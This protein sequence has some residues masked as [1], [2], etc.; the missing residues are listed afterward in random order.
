MG[1]HDEDTGR[2]LWS[3]PAP[4]LCAT[5]AMS[6]GWTQQCA[7]VMA[8]LELADDVLYIGRLIESLDAGKFVGSEY[9]LAQFL[10]P[11]L[12]DGRLRLIAEATPAEWSIIERRD[13]GFARTFQIVRLDELEPRVALDAVIAPA[14]KRLS[15]R[16]GIAI[17]PEVIERAWA[18]QRRFATEGSIIGRTL[19]FLSGV[20]RH[21]ANTY[22]SRVDAADL[23]DAFCRATGLPRALLSDDWTL[24]IEQVIAQLEQRVMGQPEA[25]RRVADVISITKAGLSQPNRPL[26]SFLFVGPTGVG[27]TELAK[28]LAATLFGD[29]ERL[30]RLDMSEYSH[31]SAYNRLR[32]EGQ[33]VQTMEL[34]AHASGDLTGPVRRQPFSVVLL[35]E[36]EKAHPSVFDL[37][38]QVLGEARLTDT[39]GRTTP[40]HNA[41]IIMTS[42]LGVDS[43]RPAIGFG[44]GKEG[45][46]RWGIT[47]GARRRDSSARSSWRAS[48]SSCRSCRSTARRSR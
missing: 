11:S 29:S 46:A 9:N 33:V 32:G 14:A 27:K 2:R 21:A 18:L 30:I 35:D 24:D 37:L 42:N 28:A 16:E 5:D 12:V 44:A 36:I 41:I 25:A 1:G 7:E 6:A 3:A 10:K 22:A 48:I 31:P 40:F 20:L 38:L 45:G 8:E 47:S 23:V 19:D 13:V 34:D 39:V 26:G 17:A 4:A 43:L 15:E